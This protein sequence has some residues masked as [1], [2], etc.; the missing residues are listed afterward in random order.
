MY[1]IKRQHKKATAIFLK[2]VPM[3]LKNQQI[4]KAHIRLFLSDGY[5]MKGNGF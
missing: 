2:I 4:E 3:K 5:R 1:A